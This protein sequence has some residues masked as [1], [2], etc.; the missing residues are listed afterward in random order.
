LENPEM[1]LAFSTK[2]PFP[3]NALKGYAAIEKELKALQ[4]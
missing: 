1:M 2:H 4:K 3:S